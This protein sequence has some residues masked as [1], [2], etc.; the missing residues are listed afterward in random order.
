MRDKG[1]KEK[2]VGVNGWGITLAGFDEE[3]YIKGR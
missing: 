3:K 2:E 1:R